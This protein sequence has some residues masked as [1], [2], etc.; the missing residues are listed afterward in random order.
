MNLMSV[1]HCSR[2]RAYFTGLSLMLLPVTLNTLE[3]VGV[4]VC[5]SFSMDLYWIEICDHYDSWELV[6]P[7]KRNA[8]L[9][10]GLYNNKPG[11]TKGV[12]LAKIS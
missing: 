7:R 9:P 6:G 12:I 3:R 1:S 5:L 8:L 10:C 4:F 11:A 2:L